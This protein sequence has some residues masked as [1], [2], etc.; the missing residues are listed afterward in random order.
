VLEVSTPYRNRTERFGHRYR[1]W[2]NA[3]FSPR[4]AAALANAE[5]DRLDQIGPLGREYFR[6]LR[7]CGP[8]TIREI[9]RLIGGWPNVRPTPQAAIAQ[10]LA[11]SLPHTGEA[12]RAE[13][14]ADAIS[15]LC[16]SGYVV[17]PRQNEQKT[18]TDV[19]SNG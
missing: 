16:R 18:G 1:A 12:E 17:S 13:L 11:M 10:A 4:A 15:A 8:Q 6:R 19:A 7:N 5:I 9:G 3:G 14:A 2:Q